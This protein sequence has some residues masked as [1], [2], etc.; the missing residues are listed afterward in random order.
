MDNLYLYRVQYT[1]EQIYSST[2]GVVATS[3][4]MAIETITKS[5]KKFR[6]I[7]AVEKLYKVD[8]IQDNKEATK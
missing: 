6:E 1:S 8:A 4:E 5:D 2:Y 3:V 7:T